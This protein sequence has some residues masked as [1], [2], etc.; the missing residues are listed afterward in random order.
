MAAA[1]LIQ[2]GREYDIG[3]PSQG[4]K[5]Q[6]EFENMFEKTPNLQVDQAAIG[7]MY[8]IV[9]VYFYRKG[10]TSKAKSIIE[11]GLIYAPNNY[12]E[13]HGNSM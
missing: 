4:A 10:Q 2:F 11:K 13:S 5:Y 7:N 12:E 6:I 3:S 1:Y 9:A 8:S